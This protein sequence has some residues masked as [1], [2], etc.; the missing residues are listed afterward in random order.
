MTELVIQGVVRAVLRGVNYRMGS[1]ANL[2]ELVKAHKSAPAG[3][4]FYDS[5][6]SVLS[7]A[8]M[9]GY[10]SVI[11]R[12][13]LEL[14][15]DGMLCLDGRPILYLK[16]YKQPCSSAERIH[17]QRLFWNQGVAN[18]LVLADPT[19]VYIYSGLAEPPGNKDNREAIERALVEEVR[20][21]DYTRQI[22]SFYHSLATGRYYEVHKDHFNPEKAV[23]IRLLEIF[24]DLRN[25]L[26]EG[27]ERL[28]PKKAHA[29][30]RA[31]TLSMLPP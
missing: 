27:E 12:A 22:H 9:L 17:L 15:L 3:M 29:F 4:M 28:D 10:I 8:G 24:R 11:R 1:A 19:S 21:V 13:W 16:E 23:D 31:H 26:I 5:L 18:I 30:S 6:D 2:T 14:K 25:A 20:L 7:D